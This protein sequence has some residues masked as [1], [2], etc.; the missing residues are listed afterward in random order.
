MYAKDVIS[1]TLNSSEHILNS[2][3]SDLEE[4][5]LKTR[6]A[7]GMN[8]IAWQLGHLVSSER[9][10]IERLKPG[11]CPELPAGFVEAH[12]KEA[13]LSEDTSRYGTKAE[14]TA[15]MAAQRKATKAVLD[16]FSDEEISAPVDNNMHGM[17]PTAGHWINFMG[18]HVLMHVGQ[19]VPIRRK[20][21]KP[22]V[23]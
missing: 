20:L 13:G 21:G 5:D 11:S 3:I 17:C 16:G 15:L 18:T 1:Q 12:G 14:Y 7:P 2:Y 10:V 9:N 4:A 23:I 8:C 6:P 19:F 22:V